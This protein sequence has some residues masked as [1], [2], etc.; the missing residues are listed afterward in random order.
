MLRNK[1]LTQKLLLLGVDGM[2]PRFTKRLVNEGK[3]P[4]FKKLMDMGSCREDL[5][6]LGANPTITPPMWATLAT[7]TYPMTH[8][9]MD[10]NIS[11]E[12]DKDIT[13]G[14]FSSVFMKAEPLF[15]VTA[16]AGKKTLVMHWPGGSFPPTTDSENLFTIDGSS[17]GACCAW[18]NERDL[19]MVYVAS[20]KCEQPSYMPLS[21]KTTDIEGDEKLS[22]ALPPTSKSGKSP[23]AKERMAYYQQWYKDK[24]GVEGYTPSGSFVVD[25]IVDGTNE[26]LMWALADFPT[27]CCLSPVWPANGW[28]IEVPADAKEFLIITFYGKVMRPALIL[29][30]ES[31]VYDKVAIYKDKASAEPLAVLE[32]DVMTGVFDTVPSANGEENVYRNM[33]MLKIAEDGSYVC[34]WA[35]RGMSCDDDSVWFPKSLFKEITDKFGPPQPTSQMSGNDKD[36]ILKCNN[37]QWTM[38]ADW[39]SKVMHHMIEEHGVEVIF[40]HMH[41]VDLQSHNYMKYMKNRPTSRYDESEV[42]KFAEA[43]YKVTDDY[44]GTFM[45]LIDEG[46]TIMIFSDHALISAYE[47]AVA[48]GD[49][50]GVCDEPFKGWGYTVMK[51]DEN[52]KELPEVDWTQTKAIMT[53]SN[54]IYINLKG[55]DKYGIVD[56]EDKYE[57]EEEIITKLYGYKHPKTGKRIIALALHN[58]DAVLLGLGGPMGAD[59]VFVVHESYVED[60]GAGLSTAWGYQDT[61]LSPIFLA[62]GPGIKENF[63]TTRYIREVDLAPTA[64]VLL[65]VDMPAQCEGAPAYQIFT[66]SM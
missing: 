2:D 65:G 21:I 3:M 48:Q 47:E 46:W 18:S 9:I 15:N 4:N 42:V 60:H 58:K 31:G 19:D 63:R 52:G 39:Q 5:M 53:R 23:E 22:F 8:G 62:A 7:G 10:Y 50:T 26:G 29:K 61:S 32:N 43:T 6:M 59:I 20:T 45:H 14:A 30:N 66:E 17:P 11:A 55:R 64:A 24:I 27:G 54:S 36:L 13:L 28:E 35:S 41:N 25:N 16:N 56:P 40:S 37:V 12:D 44:I 49:N 34:I 38:A 1:A 57:L 33:R 51:K